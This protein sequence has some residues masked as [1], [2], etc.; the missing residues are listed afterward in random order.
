MNESP[1][2]PE[3]LAE[4]SEDYEI[5]EEIGRGGTSL[6][7][8]ARDRDLDREVAI[9]VVRSQFLDDSEAGSRSDREALTLAK[10]Q[11]PNIVTLLASRRL[12]DGRRVLVMQLANGRTLRSILSQIGPFSAEAAIIVLRQV[13]WALDYLHG[14]GIIHRD[15]KPENIFLEEDG[16]VL[17]SDLGIAKTGD[18]AESVTLTGVVVGTPMYMSPEQ[19]DGLPLDH[20]SDQYSL[21]LI[22]YEMLTG[23][24]PW[25]GE[26]LYGIILKQ[27]SES[28]PPLD[29]RSDVPP[30]L[31][32][33]I[34]RAISKAADDRFADLSEFL[35]QLEEGP[36]EPWRTPGVAP[37]AAGE[38]T[39]ATGNVEPG[40]SPVMEPGR[41]AEGARQPR[42]R[43]GLVAVGLAVGLAA[44]FL[45][46]GSAWP[47]MLERAGSI[48]ASAVT[49]GSGTEPFVLAVEDEAEAGYAA[50]DAGPRPRSGEAGA[51]R[52]GE[53]EWGGRPASDTRGR[54]AA[55]PRAADAGSGLEAERSDPAPAVAVVS[56]R[57]T[58]GMAVLDRVQRPVLGHIAPPARFVAPELL[59]AD[60]VRA[61][62]ATL[63]A[64]TDAE[65]SSGGPVMLRLSIDET[66]RV[67]GGEVVGSSGQSPV[68]ALVMRATSRMRFS[69]AERNGVPVSTRLD[70]PLAIP[71]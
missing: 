45:A 60:A 30:R 65:R 31:R 11:H 10:L 1:P 51:R 52:S 36:Y 19:I 32:H 70:L 28:L 9:K 46:F 40:T 26:N 25:E 15:V 57:G 64:A 35:G 68:D 13:A 7:Y 8:L 54:G 24:R 47:W 43:R 62:L 5:I 58:D 53:A 39:A 56:I 17:L 50:A 20:R 55:E 67:T 69:P 29:S 33:A 4:L 6:V 38:R 66:G 14:H 37:R 3:D 61:Y 27:K 21:G 42:R 48:A 22:G 49:E 71:P 63:V 34:E 23:R 12:S 59:N 16:R 44:V 2:I 18:A 41:E